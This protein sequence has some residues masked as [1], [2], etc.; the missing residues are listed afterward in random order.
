MPVKFTKRNLTGVQ[1]RLSGYAKEIAAPVAGVNS[2]AHVRQ[3]GMVASNGQA[4]THHADLC[5]SSQM[6]QVP[7]AVIVVQNQVAFSDGPA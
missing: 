6:E 2:I 7:Q 1:H 5:G 4:S 3:L